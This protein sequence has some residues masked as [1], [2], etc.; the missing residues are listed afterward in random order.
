MKHMDKK[1]I[2]SILVIAAVTGASFYLL[3]SQNTTL[4]LNTFKTVPK[5]YMDA[6]CT[7]Y[8]NSDDQKNGEKLMVSTYGFSNDYKPNAF[9]IIN[10]KPENFIEKEL[11]PE[12]FVFVNEIYTIEIDREDV[13]NLDDESSRE[14]GILTITD[15]GGNKVSKNFISFCGV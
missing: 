4:S 7:Y 15:K 9:M 6:G 11:A 10:G 8:L 3:H 12:N 14:T 13:V 5:E 1:L 2:K